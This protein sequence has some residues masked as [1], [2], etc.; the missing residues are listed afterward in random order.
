MQPLGRRT[1][2]PSRDVHRK[3]FGSNTFP[4]WWRLKAL[5]R[6]E[7]S[8]IDYQVQS[9]SVTRSGR[10]ES[11]R[12][13][14]QDDTTIIRYRLYRHRSMVFVG[15]SN[16]EMPTTQ[17]TFLIP[18]W[19]DEVIFTGAYSGINA[20]RC[21]GTPLAVL[22]LLNVFF[23]REA[24]MIL[25]PLGYLQFV[26]SLE[27]GTDIWTREIDIADATVGCNYVIYK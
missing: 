16:I 14:C 19:M 12:Q 27:E 2:Q 3:T 18:F 11:E 15:C 9:N 25:D 8:E 24:C 1:S 5:T 10:C 4:A 23:W 7:L 17:R 13:Y 22:W 6:P 21:H 20:G 26:G